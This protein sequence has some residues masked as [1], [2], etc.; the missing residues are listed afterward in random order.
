VFAALQQQFR[1]FASQT[2][3]LE[4]SGFDGDQSRNDQSDTKEGGQGEE[5]HLEDVSGN[6]SNVDEKRWNLESEMLR[7]VNR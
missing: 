7:N 1:D 5:A 3:A 6:G 4:V 2:S